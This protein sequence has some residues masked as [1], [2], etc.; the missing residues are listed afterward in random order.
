MSHATCIF[1]QDHPRSRG[2]YPPS[3]RAR[4]ARRGSSP[5][6]RG[7][8]LAHGAAEL[9]VRI[10]PARAGF[11][12][13]S[14]NIWPRYSDHPRSRGVYEHLCAVRHMSVGSSPLARGL[15]AELPDRVIVRRI[16]PARAGFT[17]MTSRPH[18]PSSDHPRSRGV[19]Y[20]SRQP[21][22]QAEGSS[23][24]ARGLPG[25]EAAVEALVGI[26]PAR[27][28][29]TAR[30]RRRPG[31][32]PDH[33]RSRGVYGEG[34][35][36]PAVGRRIIPARAGF[37]TDARPV[38]FLRRDHPRSRGVYTCGSLESQR[39]RTLPDPCC[40]H[41]RPRARSAELR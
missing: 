18:S 3:S 4:S 40:L 34:A 9:S 32:R 11:T 15:L 5:L 23:P 27:A 1:F 21:S 37:T 7:L 28:G 31:G 12:P 22:R 24:L 39:T 38:R 14:P 19:Y 33:P 20:P 26:I 41:C 35:Q 2:V 13:A 10:I 8:P 17:P 29:F 6:A 36:A 25:E 30:G 16:I